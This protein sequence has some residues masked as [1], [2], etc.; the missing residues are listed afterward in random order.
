MSQSISLAG[1]TALVTGAAT[2]IG[3]AIA[4][5]LAAAGARVVVNHPHTPEPAAAVVADIAA[6]GG[7]ALA[8]AADV[9]ERAEYQAMVQRLLREGGP[10][11][12]RQRGQPGRD[13]DRD[14]SAR[15]ERAV[16]GQPGGDERVRPARP[17]G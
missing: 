4:G 10:W 14:L 12:H 8:L 2:V 13:G 11:D 17:A 9:S 3:R 5:D 1:R 6:A 15:Q 16:P 7:A